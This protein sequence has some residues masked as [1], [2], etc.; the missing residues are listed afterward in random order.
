MYEGVVFDEKLG[1][2]L[3]QLFFKIIEPCEG[4]NKLKIDSFSAG[5]Q[6]F[7]FPQEPNEFRNRL[8]LIHYV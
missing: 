2:V 7:N 3:H 6:G 1:R 8:H 5:V 4:R